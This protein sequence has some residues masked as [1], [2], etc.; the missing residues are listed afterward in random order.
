MREQI[1]EVLNVVSEVGDIECHR[2]GVWTDSDLSVH[3]NE[4][5][6]RTAH[7][8]VKTKAPMGPS[9]SIMVE[10]IKEPND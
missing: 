9:L 3:V 5:G 2:T 8:G 4:D 7:Y 10:G 1:Q 6:T